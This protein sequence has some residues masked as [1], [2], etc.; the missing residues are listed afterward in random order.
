MPEKYKVFRT[1]RSGAIFWIFLNNPDRRNAMGND[2]WS[3]I[4]QVFSEA[5]SDAESRVVILAAEGKTFCAGLDLMSLMEELPTLFN[6]D[7]ENR[8]GTQFMEV[9]RRYQQKTALPETC[10]KPVIAAIHG[11]CIGGGLD[12]VAACDIRIASEDAV[13]S[14]REVAV[15]MIADLGSLQRLPGI[16]GEGWTRQMAFSAENITAEKAQKIGLVNAVYP[17]R[18]TLLRAA[19]ELAGQ[20]AA[21]SPLAVQTTKEVLNRGRGRTIEDGLEY[22]ADRQTQLLPNSDLMEAI[23]AFMERRRPEF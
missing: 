18:E 6:T 13:F 22:A 10:R 16:I 15:A 3:E 7:A 17:D 21:N 1:E 20:I 8:A 11:H 14:L 9:I 4:S 2:F 12:L 19:S 5:E 23:A